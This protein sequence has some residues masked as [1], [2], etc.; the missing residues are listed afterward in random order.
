MARP[1]ASL[2]ALARAATEG[3]VV[4]AMLTLDICLTRTRVVGLSASAENARINKTAAL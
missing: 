3:A 2:A 1:L 4:T